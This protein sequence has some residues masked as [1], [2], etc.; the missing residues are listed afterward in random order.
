MIKS[1]SKTPYRFHGAKSP[2]SHL[3]GDR[4]KVLVDYN[5][6]RVLK[7]TGF[8]EYDY[9][10]RS[11]YTKELLFESLEKYAP[12]RIRDVDMNNQHI[13]SGLG[14][15]WRCFARPKD[16]EPLSALPLTEESVK[17][18]TSNLKASAGL[19]APNMKKVDAMLIALSNAG[20]ILDGTKKP[21]PC[22]A[23]TRTQAGGKTRLVWGYPYAM[24]VIEGLFA[25]PLITQLKNSFTPLAFAKSTGRLGTEIRVMTRKYKFIYS[26]DISSYDSSISKNLI[27]FAFSVISTWFDGDQEVHEG[28]SVKDALN[29]I[30]QYFIHTPIVMPDG[31]MYKGKRH[32]VPSGSYFTQLV[33]S[34]VNV[35]IAGA[36]GSVQNLHLG[37][38]A[39][40]VLGDDLLLGSNKDVKLETL[41]KAGTKLFGIKFNSQKSMKTSGDLVHFLGRDWLK[42]VPDLPVN[43]VLAKAVYPENFRKYS[44][45]KSERIRQVMLLL[46]SYSTT[47]KSVFSLMNK[48][49]LSNSRHC[50]MRK[51]DLNLRFRSKSDQEGEAEHTSGLMRFLQRYMGKGFGKKDMPFIAW[52]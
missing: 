41:S 5:V 34:I 50:M 51:L 31:M 52:S 49:Y 14:L 42:G 25:K 24:T 38:D 43:E 45:S 19:T 28:C 30:S 8:S 27:K 33:D 21:E 23:L 36:L 39:I 2:N 12:G 32:G 11:V 15:A 47:Y 20:K 4:L 44:K 22:L 1:F 7:E 26:M 46:Y 6:D 29:L 40:Q 48:V 37:K 3:M 35:V 10:P 16:I 9:K 17:I 18:L 13:K